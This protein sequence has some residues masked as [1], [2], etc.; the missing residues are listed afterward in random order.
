MR[1]GVA[2]GRACRCSLKRRALTFC[3]AREQDGA[4]AVDT[5]RLF[6]EVTYAFTERRCILSGQPSLHARACAPPTPEYL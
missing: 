5:L 3:A 4:I 2:E 6:D 1:F